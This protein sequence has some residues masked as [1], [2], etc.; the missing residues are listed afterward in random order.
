MV[1]LASQSCQVLSANGLLN[2]RNKATSWLKIPSWSALT[3]E[4]KARKRPLSSGCDD[5]DARA[6]C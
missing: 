6:Y 2:L 3:S 4:S 5:A 1:K